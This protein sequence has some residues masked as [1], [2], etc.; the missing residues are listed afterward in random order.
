[1]KQ[2][3]V[4][5]VA[6]YAGVIGCQLPGRI[7]E[8][9]LLTVERIISGGEFEVERFGG[10][11]WSEAGESFTRAEDSDEEVGGQDIVRYDCASGMRTVI[12]PADQLV[13]AEGSVPLHVANHTFSSDGKRVLIFTDTE[14]VWRY[15]TR[16]DYWVLDLA[17]GE[18]K[19]LGGD[20]EAATLMFAEFSPDGRRV[21]YVRQNNLYVEDVETGD[22]T[23]LTT[24]GPETV[25]N[26]TF[27]WVYEEEFG[28]RRGFRWSPDGERIAYWQI[29]TEGVGE[30]HLVNYTDDLYPRIKTFAYPKVGETNPACRVGVVSAQGGETRWLALPGDLRDNYVAWM[31]W[32]ENPTEIVLQ[33]L[34]RLQNTNR[35]MLGDPDTGEVR[36][37]FTDQ[38]SAWVDVVRDLHWIRDGKAFTWISEQDGWRHVYVV[39]RDGQ[40][41]CCVTQGDYDVVD[42]VS[43]DDESGH[44]YFTACP[45]DPTESY[46][47]RVPLDG[48]ATAAQLS[49]AEQFGTHSY[50]KQ[51]NSP[52]AIHTF[53][54]FGTPPVV[55]LVRLPEHQVVRTLAD[56]LAL[57]EKL[58]ATARGPAEL[59]RIDIG[60]GVGLDGWCIKPPDFKP[61]KRYPLLFYVYGEPAG[62]T[63]RNAWGGRY[64]LWH[65]MLAQQGYLVMSV[66]NRGTTAPRGREWRKCIY[67][68]VGILASADQAAAT[69]AICERWPYVDRERIGTWGWSGGGSMSLNAIFR[70]PELYHTAIAIAFVCNQRY[71]DTIYQERYMGL[72]DDN[73]DGYELGSPITYAHQLEGNLLLIYGTGDDNCH[74]QNAEVL[75]NKL[76][77][78]NKR[79]T[80]MPYPNRTHNLDEGPNTSRHM[81][82][83]MTRFL[84]E[85]LP[86]GPRSR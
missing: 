42:F 57:R 18:L 66:D 73:P 61:R 60:D 69:R 45:D 35:V 25:I 30:F 85:N 47:Y 31:D 78:E 40:E 46:L 39:S 5:L 12:V 77:E 13:P 3:I 65:L 24:D 28:L 37:I 22:I 49:P 29:D 84:N 83:L 50:A 75:V 8:A 38:D 71:Y 16:G 19:R 79:F 74:Y 44:L 51:P 76:V 48:S 4:A 6:L 82:E 26:G 81:Y 9:R 2:A 86:P 41:V 34:N 68:Q 21:A 54:S 58:A 64:Y 80:I 52:W 72:P 27:D 33:R 32:A 20:A 62:R 59:F 23:Q 63:V 14:R 67:R 70:H 53:S 43:V 11:R 7:N 55:E 36:V 15:E 56:N 10:A 1:M 17:T